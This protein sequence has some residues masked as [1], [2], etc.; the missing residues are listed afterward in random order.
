MNN[1]RVK[2]ATF[3]WAS[4]RIVFLFPFIPAMYFKW[5]FSSGSFL[6]RSHDNLD[7][8][9]A[10]HK[11]L[12][13]I[14]YLRPPWHTWESMMNGIP[15]AFGPTPTNISSLLVFALPASLGQIMLYAIAYF[16][17]YLGVFYI[18]WRLNPRIPNSAPS[19][20]LANLI[21]SSYAVALAY[22]PLALFHA[23]AP[24]YLYFL[25]TRSLGSKH[26]GE[27][28]IHFLFGN[29][30]GL[31][32]GVP[33][34][35]MLSFFSLYNL[36]RKK[37]SGLFIPILLI[38][39]GIGV[40]DFYQIFAHFFY[41]S[42]RSSSWAVVAANDLSLLPVD[43][44]KLLIAGDGYAPPILTPG[45]F[46]IT[47]LL[48][49]TMSATRTSPRAAD[50]NTSLLLERFALLTV[51]APLVAL[52]TPNLTNWFGGIL[53]LEPPVLNWDRALW[54]IPS[55]QAVLVA[56]IACEFGKKRSHN[57]RLSDSAD[58]ESARRPQSFGFGQSAF[59]ASAQS[60]FKGSL[61]LSVVVPSM[62]STGVAL[63]QVDKTVEPNV[64]DYYQSAE[65][66]LLKTIV[67][68]DGELTGSIGLHP[69][70]ASVNGFSTIDGYLSSYPASY[71]QQFLRLMKP[72]IDNDVE[73]KYTGYLTN[74]GSRAYL[75]QPSV[76]KIPATYRPRAETIDV[77]L[78]WSIARELGLHF[79][80]ST[81]PLQP[82]PSTEAVT[83]QLEAKVPRNPQRSWRGSTDLYLYSIQFQSA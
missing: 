83:F 74:W 62:L 35:A 43:A 47:F 18:I 80:L 55:L 21:A 72:S 59:L 49:V 64:S 68:Y 29:L 34:L 45:T 3:N 50:S 63:H 61:T 66:D 20:I 38:S 9:V 13:V 12:S 37:T 69:A 53:R 4:I 42:H 40:G 48:I 10:A 19:L 5:H 73:D 60:F 36:F 8:Y 39:L 82:D 33:F 79:L 81:S 14:N 70:V 2:S 23:I 1:I 28:W 51:T 17:G 11:S 76:G 46:W 57:D 67:D 30:L 58:V 15:R 65:F 56:V 75:F 26:R 77:Y 41:E 71:H 54:T 24:P 52:G 31:V 44:T 16:G 78:D 7:G 22:P 25:L 27:R 32:A 6:S